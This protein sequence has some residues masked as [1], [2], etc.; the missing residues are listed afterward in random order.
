MVDINLYRSLINNF[1]F[2]SQAQERHGSAEDRIQRLEAQVEEK[3]AELLR[4][5]QRLKMNEEH[6]TRLSST[7]DK[8]LSESNERLQVHLKER[9]HALEEKN[10]LTQ[11]LDKTRKYVEQLEN[12]KVRTISFPEE[13][14]TITPV[15]GRYEKIPILYSAIATRRKL[16]PLKQQQQ[17]KDK[18]RIDYVV[19]ITKMLTST[20]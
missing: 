18:I 8:L 10:A 4:L 17:G 16:K 7:V 19:H 13:L 14:E 1:T 2:F 6:N 20:I 11:E 9:M 5:N 3:N 12:E 15:Y